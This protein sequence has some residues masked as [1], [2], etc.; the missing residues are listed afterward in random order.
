MWFSSKEFTCKAAD[1]G[2]TGSIPVLGRSPGE[3]NGSLPQYSCWENPMDRGAWWAIVHRVTESQ[4]GLK[5][6]SM[7]EHLYL[8][9]CLSVYLSIYLLLLMACRMLVP[10]PGVE[11]G[12]LAV[13]VWSPN[14]WTTREFPVFLLESQLMLVFLKTLRSG[15]LQ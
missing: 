4:T 5:W 8:S 15:I 12:P 10:L 6:L 14:H 2:E 11:P 13:K 1:T 9:V 7:L 3:G